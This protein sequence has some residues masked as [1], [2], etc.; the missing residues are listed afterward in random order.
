MRT[1]YAS[2]LDGT[3]LGSDSLLSGNTV[4]MLNDVIGRGALFTV[5][6]ARTP[7]TVSRLMNDVAMP[8]PAVVMTGTA[9][10]NQTDGRITNRVTIPELTLGPLLDIYRRHN[11]PTF[12]YTFEGEKIMVYHIGRL[13]DMERD[14]MNE[15]SGSPYKIF[16]VPEDG[17]SSL[18][19]S[20]EQV[21]LLYSMQPGQEIGE[22]YHE[23]LSGG[24]VN[25][26]YY[27]DFFGPDTGILEV[28]PANASKAE[29]LK[30]LASE[31]GADRLVVFGDNI[32]DIPMMRL[33]DVAVA[34]ENAVDQV[35]EEADIVIGPND[36]DSVA[37]FIT[38]D[39]NKSSLT[40]HF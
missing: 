29:A 21:V 40:P 33:A 1:L 38:A 4:R 34:V 2:D 14:F 31:S 18:P 3:L 37:R 25:P 8:L 24:K 17:D 6:T 5:A 9:L 35:K 22:V 30:R 23:I 7:A 19:E 12:V 36:E 39:F 15:R 32:N 26:L 13:S 20:L 27:H 10:W 11:L 28:F 16:D